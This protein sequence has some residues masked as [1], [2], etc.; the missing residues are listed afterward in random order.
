MDMSKIVESFVHTLSQGGVVLG[1]S[2][3]CY[4]LFCDAY[5]SQALEKVFSLKQKDRGKPV[6]MIVA[7]RAMA[8]QYV[9]WDQQVE[10]MWERYAY[11]PYTMIV[12][13]KTDVALGMAL[14]Y[15]VGIRVPQYDLLLEVA[16]AFGKP[17]AVT[18]AN[19][20]GNSV[21]YSIDDVA[22]DIDITQIDYVCDIGILPENPPSTLVIWNQ[23]KVELRPRT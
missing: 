5:S 15:R 7:D 8:E 3:T 2:D 16:K 23:K 17:I 4:D 10:E 19:T 20:S 11:G 14:H 21:H 9:L 6:S 13:K 12:P 22:Q 1:P 18:S